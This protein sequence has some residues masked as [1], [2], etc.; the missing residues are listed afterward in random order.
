M[1]LIEGLKIQ[2][3]R[4]LREIAMGRIGNGYSMRYQKRYLGLAQ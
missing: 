3:Y 2:N 1:A 4:S